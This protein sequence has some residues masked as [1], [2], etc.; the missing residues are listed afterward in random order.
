MGR[1][2]EDR[3]GGDQVT[4]QQEF[5]NL[6]AAIRKL[7]VPERPSRTQNEYVV[8]SVAFGEYLFSRIDRREMLPIVIGLRA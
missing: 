4:G 5:Q 8:G 7:N 1:L 3:D 2:L 6:P